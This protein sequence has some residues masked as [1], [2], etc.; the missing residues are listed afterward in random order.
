MFNFK[1]KA[2]DGKDAFQ[3]VQEIKEVREVHA[4]FLKWLCANMALSS[5][6][7]FSAEMTPSGASVVVTT[8]VGSLTSYLEFVRDANATIGRVAFYEAEEKAFGIPPRV[9][10]AIRLKGNFEINSGDEG[11]H[12]WA[13]R[14]N[15]W[16][17]SEASRLGY[18]LLLGQLAPRG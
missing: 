17:R 8:P 18:E 12:K 7:D 5:G 15:G 4:A 16:I 9:V 6:A 14:E 11:G 3:A 1:E 10:F 13:S 2:G